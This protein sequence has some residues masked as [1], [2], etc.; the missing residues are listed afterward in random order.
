MTKA[1]RHVHIQPKQQREESAIASFQEKALTARLKSFPAA[2]SRY[3]FGMKTPSPPPPIR[4]STTNTKEKEKSA[5]EIPPRKIQA[6]TS[7]DRKT[8][9]TRSS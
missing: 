5:P 3:M 8:Q 4:V 9:L 6:S 7:N 2:N 1:L